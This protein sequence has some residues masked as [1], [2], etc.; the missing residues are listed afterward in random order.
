MM[1][2]KKVVVLRN[3]ARRKYE[4]GFPWFQRNDVRMPDELGQGE[5]VQLE[6]QDGSFLGV[7]MANRGARF[8]VKILTTEDRA[9]DADFFR[10]RLDAA[11]EYRV[12][13]DLES[14]AWRWV[15]GEADGL[16][17]LIVDWFDG[18]VAV[19][20]R[21]AG[22][23]RLKD[24]WAPV[25][26]ERAK[27]VYERSDMAGRKEEGLEDVNGQ[28]SGETPDRVEIFER[29]LKYLVPIKDGLKTGHFLDQRNSRYRLT[30]RVK[31][32]EKV[33]DLFCYSGGFSLAACAAGANSLGVDL[34]YVAVET[35]KANAA[36]NGFEISFVQANAFDFLAQEAGAHGPYDW[37]ILDP[38]AIGKTKETRDSLK[39]GVW[40]LVHDAL[41]LLA[42][43]GK[44]LVCA[45]TWQMNVEDCWE[46]IQLAAGDQGVR[47]VLE[48]VTLQDLDHPAVAHFPQ[49]LYLKCLWVRR[50]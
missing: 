12:G 34:K 18:H 46:V 2:A 14:N 4:K 42:A 48:E 30:E 16:P 23:E 10:E 24:I 40:K 41:P 11:W 13:M 28:L 27:S 44:M 19:Q 17:G 31:A 32:G 43:N 8:P 6:G 45:C 20:V 29:K 3:G 39:W 33:L 38:P 50:I 26:A 35:G 22:M 25:L 37:V 49:S 47:V 1:K 5:L 21:N 7:G 9:I 15:H 36:A